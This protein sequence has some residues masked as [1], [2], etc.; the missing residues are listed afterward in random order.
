MPLSNTPLPPSTPSPKPQRPSN[1][2]VLQ[3]SLD[4]LESQHWLTRLVRIIKRAVQR[5]I[6]PTH[7]Y[8]LQELLESLFDQDPH[9]QM[10]I[11]LGLAIKLVTGKMP[12]QFSERG[13]A[14]FDSDKIEL[15]DAQ[16]ERLN[17]LVHLNAVEMTYAFF[18][19]G[20][21]LPEGFIEHELK[22]HFHTKIRIIT[23]ANDFVS[24]D[25]DDIFNEAGIH[26][27]KDLSFSKILELKRII[28]DNFGS[29]L[30]E[31]DQL[32]EV[33]TAI[34]KPQL[35]KPS[36]TQTH[37]LETE[38]LE[39]IKAY[40]QNT[41]LVQQFKERADELKRKLLRT[42]SRSLVLI[43][44]LIAGAILAGFLT[45]GMSFGVAAGVSVGIAVSYVTFWLATTSLWQQFRLHRGINRMR[46]LLNEHPTPDTL[47]LKQR[48]TLVSD[49]AYQCKN[50]SFT[51]I[52]NEVARI[53]KEIVD[54]RTLRAQ[55][56]SSVEKSIRCEEKIAKAQQ[57]LDTL[58]TELA[59]YDALI[60]NV[61]A[62]K[63][64]C[65]EQVES[66]LSK[67]WQAKFSTKDE[68]ELL[69]LFEYANENAVQLSHKLQKSMSRQQLDNIAPYSASDKY[70]LPVDI[71]KNSYRSII[72]HFGFVRAITKGYILK[73]IKV[74]VFENFRPLEL[75]KRLIREGSE[76]RKFVVYAPRI[77]VS[78]VVF[79]SA[80]FVLEL[81]A[82][83]LNANVNKMNYE[84]IKAGEKGQ[85]FSWWGGRDRS[86][87]EEIATLRSMAKNGS[88]DL[89][90]RLFRYQ[91]ALDELHEKLTDTP[92]SQHRFEHISEE[93]AAII[94]INHAIEKQLLQDEIDDI[95]TKFKH[96]VNIKTDRWR[97]E[98]GKRR[99]T[100]VDQTTS[101][102]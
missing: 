48:R 62:L 14:N 77:S 64:R 50:Q 22:P 12:F 88:D 81:I 102:S 90:H 3:T 5:Q 61:L 54:L 7:N 95:F 53:E 70:S 79:Y 38:D 51:R 16:R 76:P 68:A 27:E 41:S 23:P 15:T 57:R 75:L 92:E 28:R 91:D 47:T 80:F 93:E 17:H 42:K 78:T 55:N 101:S 59:T 4:H 36:K 9:L 25:I 49:L 10:R 20:V 6:E 11:R 52:Y 58:T 26:N 39:H 69:Q 67:L 73:R 24:I 21:P 86:E 56:V 65:E 13:G 34:M 72:N 31:L 94:F 1:T 96:Y 82:N 45:A 32:P 89:M 87:R 18:L 8:H 98:I 19:D 30:E 60:D 44:D 84:I 46:A 63:A 66:E 37:F 74:A 100:A 99:V 43:I 83:K 71:R 85:T 33:N 97:A 29:S 2:P 35:D 40:S